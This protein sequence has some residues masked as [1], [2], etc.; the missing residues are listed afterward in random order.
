MGKTWTPIFGVTRHFAV[1]N[2]KIT[3]TQFQLKPASGTTIHG[4]EGCTLNKIC[5]D[6]D[7]SDSP[8]LSKNQS[9]AKCFLHHAH[10][11]AA[12]RV[13]TLE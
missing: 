9:L 10:Y 2:G 1:S 5:I 8:G 4:A 3:I 11:V 12:S 6:M 13:T 7:L